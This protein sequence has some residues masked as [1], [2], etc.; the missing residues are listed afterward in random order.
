MSRVAGKHKKMKNNSNSD[1]I[2][3]RFNFEICKI[4]I[5]VKRK[6]Y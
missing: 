5:M 6:K 3:Q 4:K 2:T 1:E